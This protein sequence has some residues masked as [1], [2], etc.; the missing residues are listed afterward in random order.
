MVSN[1]GTRPVVLRNWHLLTPYLTCNVF[2]L[3]LKYKRQNLN[4]E[5]KKFQTLNN[6]ACLAYLPQGPYYCSRNSNFWNLELLL[7][8]LLLPST[9][10][11]PLIFFLLQADDFQVVLASTCAIAGLSALSHLS[12]CLLHCSCSVI[13]QLS[14]L[15][16]F[17]AHQKLNIHVNITLQHVC[18][19][20]H[21]HYFAILY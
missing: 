20:F 13:Q 11:Q 12:E 8:L 5:Q 15:V 2:Y 16:I 1:L 17:E 21:T 10:F 9:F 4:L 3:S 18:C 19:Y 7:L 6:N 14:N